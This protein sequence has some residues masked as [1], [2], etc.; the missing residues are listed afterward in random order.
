MPKKKGEVELEEETESWS[1]FSV[2]ING[3]II[4]LIH[5]ERIQ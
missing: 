4:N 5:F 2:G 3:E 1:R